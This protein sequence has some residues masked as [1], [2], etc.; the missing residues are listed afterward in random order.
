MRIAAEA[1]R[2][3]EVPI[4]LMTYYNIVY[5]NGVDRFL[6][7]AKSHGVDGVIVPDLPFDESESYSR[8]SRRMGVDGILLAAPTTPEPRMRKLVERTSGF[9]YLV[10]LLGVTGA[11]ASMGESAK[12]LISR[13]SRFTEGR[14]PLA[15]GFG[16]SRPEH[17]RAVMLA[18]GNAAIVG[19]AL[20][21]IVAKH[22]GD[23]SAM[24]KE[25]G[26]Y[27]KSMKEATR[28]T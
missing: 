1:K 13:V 10:S 8:L 9:L 21:D 12:R 28:G 5:A 25:L 19:S 14:V 16:I 23:R 18:G 2:Q 26:C 7:E 24:A 15:V 20:V 27:V 17:V 6:G 3:Y 4:V 11:R 22:E